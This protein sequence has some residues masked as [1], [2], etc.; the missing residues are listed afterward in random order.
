MYIIKTQDLKPDRSKSQSRPKYIELHDKLD[1]SRAR[2]ARASNIGK[3][4]DSNET[5][6]S[7]GINYGHSKTRIDVPAHFER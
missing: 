2:K 6:S 5:S 1:S 3:V 4:H 7:L